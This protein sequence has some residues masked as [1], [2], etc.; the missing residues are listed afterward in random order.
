MKTNLQL[1]LL[2]RVTEYYGQNSR[3]IVADLPVIFH[4]TNNYHI[5]GLQPNCSISIANALEILQSCT[6][7]SMMTLLI[8]QV[9]VL[10]FLER[11]FL[12]PASTRYRR[13]NYEPKH[14]HHPSKQLISCMLNL[15]SDGHIGSIKLANSELLSTFVPIKLGTLNCSILS[16]LYTIFKTKVLSPFA[17]IKR[18]TLK[19]VVQYSHY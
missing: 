17:P 7:P 3:N 4:A 13:S 10:L 19:Y 15:T 6:K 8:I 18:R 2:H 14:I 16:L 11:E 12:L 1:T 9:L 5:D